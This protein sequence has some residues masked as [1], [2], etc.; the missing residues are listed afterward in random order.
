[1]EPWRCTDELPE[2]ECTTI[3]AEQRCR[4]HLE[5]NGISGCNRT[6]GFCYQPSGWI[7]TRAPWFPRSEYKELV[8]SGDWWQSY[9]H[10]HG[11]YATI[12]VPT[13]CRRLDRLEFLVKRLI[14]EMQCVGEV[15]VVARDPCHSMVERMLRN[16][17]LKP[18]LK[19]ASEERSLAV[20][21][22]NMGDWDR[23]YGPASRFLAAQKAR[24]HVIVHLDDDELPCERQVCGLA[25]AALKE[26][27]GIYGHHKRKCNAIKGYRAAGN[28]KA[29]FNYA[30]FDVL[31]TLF[32]STS[33]AFNDIFVRNFDRYALALASARGNGEDIAYSHFLLQHFN[34]TP[35]Y[36]PRE[37]C[38]T[39]QVNGIVVENYTDGF[40]HLNDRYIC[41]HQW[42]KKT[43][44]AIGSKPTDVLISQ[45]RYEG[46][47]SN[48]IVQAADDYLST[49]DRIKANPKLLPMLQRKERE[50]RSQGRDVRFIDGVLGTVSGSAVPRTI[51]TYSKDPAGSGAS[52]F[53]FRRVHSGSPPLLSS[54]EYL[55]RGYDIRE[56][57]RRMHELN[58]TAQVALRL[59]VEGDELFIHKALLET[60]GT[61]LG[62][63]DGSLL[64]H[65]DWMFTEHQNLHVNLTEY[66]LPERS[67]NVIG[68]LKINWRNF[69]SACGGHARYVWSSKTPQ[70]TGMN[71]S[72]RIAAQVAKSA[73]K[74]KATGK[75][76]GR[77]RLALGQTSS[78][79]D[80]TWPQ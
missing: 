58:P 19:Q 12:V 24:G 60:A 1:M 22:V 15:M 69:W 27:I 47:P 35:T 65:V 18:S 9:G 43:W 51:V 75:L 48:G 78:S 36:I 74:K 25:A 21:L 31:L 41:R 68:H 67:Y 7:P 37:N 16:P 52:R 8:S 4:K 14:T 76:R 79:T 20:G 34:R 53:D 5:M 50:H 13:I 10:A 26:P 73:L 64:C 66:G 46:W 2:S 40:S 63:G 28:P 33:R 61:D 11:R 38:W 56:I 49:V 44:D 6:C 3:K 72:E 70:A 62:V 42:K 57:I 45:P 59:D 77:R 17:Q 54:E 23:I 80:P 32:A 39:W 71:E 29:R 30:P 55:G